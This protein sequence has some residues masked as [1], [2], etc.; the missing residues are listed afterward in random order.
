MRKMRNLEEKGKMSQPAPKPVKKPAVK[1]VFAER[2]QS[3]PQG[4]IDDLIKQ[5]SAQAKEIH[6]LAKRIEKLEKSQLPLK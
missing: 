6:E 1:D 5:T 4:V 2:R 3:D